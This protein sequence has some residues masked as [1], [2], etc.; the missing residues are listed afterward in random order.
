MKCLSRWEAMLPTIVP[1]IVNPS[2]GLL[3]PTPGPL[4]ASSGI[5]HLTLAAESVKFRK[6]RLAKILRESPCDPLIYCV[7]IE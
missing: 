5:C 7:P 2:E 3:A 4:E 6:G 1:H